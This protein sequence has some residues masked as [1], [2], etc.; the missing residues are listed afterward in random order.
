ML[1]A[2]LNPAG[3]DGLT[4]MTKYN[5]KPDKDFYGAVEIGYENFSSSLKDP[6]F[7]Y[8]N[9]IVWAQIDIY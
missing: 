4:G 8:Y 7:T 9:F 6:W 1:E 2:N 5:R 3:T